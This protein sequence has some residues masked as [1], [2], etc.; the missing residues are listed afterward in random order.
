MPCQYRRTRPNTRKSMTRCPSP[1]PDPTSMTRCPS[2][3]PPRPHKLPEQHS[4][5]VGI[6]W[7]DTYCMLDVHALYSY[8][9]ALCIRNVSPLR[10]SYRQSANFS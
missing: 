5:S 1:F 3:L 9:C 4:Q 8:V 2:P 7:C 6:L 10:I